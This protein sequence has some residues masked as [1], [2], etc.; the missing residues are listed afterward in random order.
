[1]QLHRCIVYRHRL[2]KAK[3]TLAESFHSLC[4]VS[5]SFEQWHRLACYSLCLNSSN[6]PQGLSKQHAAQ[7]PGEQQLSD[8]LCPQHVQAQH[9]AVACGSTLYFSIEGNL[10]LLPSVFCAG[11]TAATADELD[12]VSATHSQ[13]GLQTLSSL[14]RQG[15]P[16]K[17]NLQTVA[18]QATYEP[19]SH[20]RSADSHL[21]SSMSTQCQPVCKPLEASAVMP[22][23]ANPELQSHAAAA[24]AALVKA[25]E[26]SIPRPV[27]D[28]EGTAAASTSA[29][30]QAST[31]AVKGDGASEPAAQVGLQLSVLS[32]DASFVMEFAPTY[33]PVFAPVFSPNAIAYPSTTSA[34]PLAAA[35]PVAAAAAAAQPAFGA[36]AAPAESSCAHAAE[37]VTAAEAA[38]TAAG[39]APLAAR[40]EAGQ[41]VLQTVAEET[42]AATPELHDSSGLPFAATSDAIGQGLPA[43]DQSPLTSRE[44][45]NLYLQPEHLGE[46]SDVTAVMIAA[47]LE[48]TAAGAKAAA[49]ARPADKAAREEAVRLVVSV[50]WS[51]MQP[52]YAADPAATI[53]TCGLHSVLAV[54]AV[55]VKVIASM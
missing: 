9:E 15:I 22:D 23:A 16:D 19:T 21:A 47:D 53:T 40:E 7:Q 36:A 8:C 26:A 38:L 44:D 43:T 54:S 55:A 46:E 30:D 14:S 20:D 4:F 41:Q 52:L 11:I 24:A 28:P 45:V 17:A 27:A 42:A 2:D 5:K 37:L 32:P 3:L 33:S 34:A 6:T 39:S 51:C 50:A 25:S 49:D 35:L 12:T 18:H 31:A 10:Q 13:D 29:A 1:M 48:G